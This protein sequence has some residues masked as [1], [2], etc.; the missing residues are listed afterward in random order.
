MRRLLFAL[1]LAPISGLAS[2]QGLLELLEGSPRVVGRATNA[3]GALFLELDSTPS[4]VG[5]ALRQGISQEGFE[6]V[7]IVTPDDKVRYASVVDGEVFVFTMDWWRFVQLDHREFRM[8]NLTYEEMGT[9]L[10]PTAIAEARAARPAWATGRSQSSSVTIPRN[11][12]LSNTTSTS[13]TMTCYSNGRVTFRS[14]CT[15]SR[16]TFAISCRSDSY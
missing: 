16:V 12:C 8:N 9:Y 5:S 14:V 15:I 6:H 13:S 10:N 11:G 2:A 4:N 3:T 1:A 7:A